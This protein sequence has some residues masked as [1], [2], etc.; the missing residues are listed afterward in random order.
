M[1][2][3]PTKAANCEASYLPAGQGVLAWIQR[4]DP[5]IGARTGEGVNWMPR[6]WQTF[7]TVSKAGTLSPESAL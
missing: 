4:L 6:A 1:V 2:P 3:P 5:G 7:K